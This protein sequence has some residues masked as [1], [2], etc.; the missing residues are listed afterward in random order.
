MDKLN[1]PA[2][3]A[4]SQSKHDRMVRIIAEDL[5]SKGYSVLADHIGWPKGAPGLIN[6]YV[7]DLT[8]TNTDWFVIFEVKTRST[9]RDEHTREQ[10]TAFEQKGGTFIIVPP[11]HCLDHE[12]FDLVAEVKQILRNWGLFSVRV[13]TCDPLTGEIDYFADM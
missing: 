7:P 8:V 3:S 10:L 13:G 9:Y 5:A 4:E 11:E 12:R 6:G 1:N 2:H